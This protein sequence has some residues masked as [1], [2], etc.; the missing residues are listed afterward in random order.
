MSR[1]GRL[2]VGSLAAALLLVLAAA[3]GARADAC[4]VDLLAGGG[5]EALTGT[6]R[7]GDPDGLGGTGL[8][9]EPDGLG[10]TGLG[11]DD[12]LGG[13]GVFGTVTNLG[14]VC[15]NGLEIHYAPDVPV[16]KD[17]RGA[18]AARL[19]PG[20]VVFARAFRKDGRLV[21]DEI[22]IWTA[23][24]GRIEAVSPERRRLVVSGERV[25]ILARAVVLGPQ[26]SRRTLDVG[27][28]IEVSGLRRADGT[29]V[30]S[31]IEPAGDRSVH[32]RRPD[33][34]A[35]LAAAPSLSRV[36][37]EAYLDPDP[38]APATLHGLSAE[39]PGAAWRAHSGDRVRISGPL[40]GDT[41][42]V[43]RIVARPLL[44]E[45]PIDRALDVPQPGE[46]RSGPP[47]PPSAPVAPSPTPIAPEPAPERSSRDEPSPGPALEVLEPP[48][49]PPDAPDLDD[50]V[51]DPAISEPSFE[52]EP[53][54]DL[55]RTDL[56]PV[57]TP[58]DSLRR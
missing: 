19:A 8:G 6:G 42:V 43:E 17:G 58:D 20:Q 47:P 46:R 7:A 30:A 29:L 11:G 54:L 24:V 40:R 12:G 14:S 56:D 16:R 5:G 51:L 53:A 57:G 2:A 37:I 50:W 27:Q 55:D 31:R 10:G 35:W 28:W 3:E 18:D 48:S 32:V 45:P 21:A 49:P 36:S 38:E 44:A 22:T 41:L 33:L 52:R 25:E 15:V 13:T 34:A 9:G 39:A 23:L 4:A 26:G 1:A